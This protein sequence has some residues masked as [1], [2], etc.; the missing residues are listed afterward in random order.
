VDR[1]IDAIDA[2]WAYLSDIALGS[3]ALAVACHFVKTL[4]TGRAWRNVLAAAYPEQRVPFRSVYGAYISGV[5]VNSILP[6]RS[7]DVVRVWFAHRAIPGASYATVIASSVV[8]TFV[9]STLALLLFAWALTQGLLPSLDVLPRLPSFDFHWFFEHEV[10]SEIIVAVLAILLVV[11]ILLVR[12]RVGRLRRHLAQAFN[13]FRP[14][15]RYLRTVATWQLCDWA[16]RL[17]TIWF[18]LGAFGIHQ[19]IRNVLLVQVTLSL[20]T[21]V[22]ISPGGVGTEQA[23]I[24][25]VFR[26]IAPASIVV[27]FSVGMKITLTVV[28]VVL[29]FLSIALTLRTLRVRHAIRTARQATAEANE[30]AATEKASR[31]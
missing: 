27:P 22:P 11:T 23:L 19:S 9:D 5:G 21:L 14:K 26:G 20:S 3:L 28:N 30:T 7:G 8:L 6:A 10:V 12:E 15:S 17:T 13:V 1:V 18:F 24:A 4:C 2:F 25:Y 16:L 29:A 31:R